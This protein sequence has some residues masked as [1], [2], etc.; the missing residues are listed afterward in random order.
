MGGNITGA[1]ATAFVISVTLCL[2]LWQVQAR[3]RLGLMQRAERVV[4]LGLGSLV[5]GLAW[6]GF[7]LNLIIIIVAVLTNVTAIHRIVWVYKHGSGIPLNEGLDGASS[8]GPSSG[9]EE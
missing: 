7:V 9:S 6:N 1:Q 3:S 4:L 2:L 8:A 5:F